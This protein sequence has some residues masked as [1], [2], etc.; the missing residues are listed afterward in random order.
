M[1][2]NKGL[3]IPCTSVLFFPVFAA[4][5]LR[6]A[7]SPPRL[8][9]EIPSSLDSNASFASR[10]GFLDTN[11]PGFPA[12]KRS[13]RNSFRMNTCKSVSKQRT[14][15]PFR[16][17][18]YEKYRGEGVLWLT[19]YPMREVVPS[20]KGSLFASGGGCLSRLPSLPRASRG[21]Q[22]Q[23]ATIGSRGTCRRDL[24]SSLPARSRSRLRS[25]LTL[26]HSYT[27]EPCNCFRI[28]S[29]RKVTS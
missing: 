20:R 14:L 3:D 18:T 7:S 8:C 6:P 21:A 23:G 15:T 2:P 22:A 28:T 13:S 27:L 24:L 12:C 1:I 19:N 10:M 4:T 26:L 9:V 29:W 16:M 25:T 11:F 5:H 17:N